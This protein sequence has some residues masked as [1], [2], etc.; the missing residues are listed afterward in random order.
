MTDMPAQ[1]G[2]Y[3]VDREIGRGGMGVVYLARDT[4][5]DR[6]VAIKTLPEKWATDPERLARFERE[7]RSLAQLNH[8]NVAGIYGVEE[9]NGHRFL[10]LEYVEGD[11][12]SDR[13]DSRALPTDEALELAVEIAAGVEAAHEA[14]V[15]HRDLKPDNIK[16]TPDG[17]VKVLDFGIAKAIETISSKSHTDALTVTTASR[18]TV[19]GAII[20]TAPYMSP[21]QARGRPICKRSDIW[22]FGVI[23][24]EMLTG[25][26]PFAGESV[27]DSIGSVLHKSV[28]LQ[29]LP[30]ECPA[31]VRRVL[32]RCL[33]RDPTRRYCD[34][35]DVRIDLGRSGEEGREPWRDVPPSIASG[36]RFWAAVFAIILVG[37]AGVIGGR[38]LRPDAELAGARASDSPLSRWSIT[39]PSTLDIGLRTDAG[40]YDYSHLLAVADDG[41][42]AY[43]V[44]DKN[45]NVVIHVKRPN[46]HAGTPVSG[47]EGGRAPFFSPNG[48]WL[49]F[50]ASRHSDEGS[51]ALMKV[52]LNGGAAR[53]L[54]EL[55]ES[56]SFDGSWSPDGRF[57]V[58]ATDKGLW[59]IDE[60]GGV[61]TRLIVPSSKDG[62]IG[63][64]FPRVL[65]DS[66]HVLFTIASTAE[67]HLAILSL[68]T[69]VYDRLIPNA[70]QG[71]PLGDDRL[72]FAHEGELLTV[73]Y[74]PVTL[75][76]GTPTPVLQGVHT[77]PGLGGVVVT[78]FDLSADGTLVYAPDTSMRTDDQL[79]WVEV[80]DGEKQETLVASGPGTWVHPRL[81]PE[82]R[83]VSVDIHRPD[84]M[85]DIYM[86]DLRRGEPI[87]RRLTFNG[88]TW[89]SEWRPGAAQELAVM[90]AREAGRWGVHLVRADLISQET[91]ELVA[92]AHLI[93]GSWTKDGD[94]LLY[95]DLGVPG[96]WRVIVGSDGEPEEMVATQIHERFPR[97]SPNNE[98]LAYVADGTRAPEV[99][100]ARYPELEPR[101]QVTS[102]GGTEPVWS[103][104]GESLFYR[105]DDRVHALAI[106]YEP[107]FE[108][109]ERGE[110]FRGDY[111]AASVGHQHYDVDREGERFLMIK[112][113]ALTGP[114]EIRAVLNW[115]ERVVRGRP[116][117]IEK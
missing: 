101:Y 35:G 48:E 50:F 1:I 26:N 109:T 11:T 73:S 68:E 117:N 6:D 106:A 18:P 28:D 43:T 23:L 59:R 82:G 77:T 97:L 65:A 62:E 100:V 47:T 116:D 71:R 25:T 83:R 12:L 115:G 33:E 85:R 7:A 36:R 19:P 27:N 111:D 107:T 79:L 86:F 80:K 46:D 14:G 81:S 8:P 29:R 20:G 3:R 42:I 41:A 58:Y 74:D 94:T 40:Q 24:Y 113:G 93:P 44:R 15:I 60:N 2:P 54:C 69:G 53:V 110:L 34:I 49:G 75:E 91:A 90:S 103:R 76:T 96:I 30:P 51:L 31:D 92:G 98:W 9:Q 63:H 108:W 22:S 105:V 5:L 84:G 72:V 57:I 99:W 88:V 104:D 13:I 10:I 114:N 39:L 112:H 66:K 70:A 37:S 45:D 67:T 64:H 56:A 17:K 21:E 4:K 16:V 55:D 52:A 87:E 61:P 38:A 78:Q 102:G 89:E 32:S 95:H